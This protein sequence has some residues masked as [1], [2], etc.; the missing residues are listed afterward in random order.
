MAKEPI[1]LVA[2]E[3]CPLF[4]F[5]FLLDFFFREG[6]HKALEGLEVVEDD[7]LVEAEL[8]DR[9]GILTA[10]SDDTF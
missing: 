3:P 7:V 9:L 5:V 6:L 4:F 1:E 10:R 2:D 8:P